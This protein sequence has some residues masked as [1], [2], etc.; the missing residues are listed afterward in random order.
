MYLEII[1]PKQ[2]TF[3][4]EVKLIQLPGIEGS[5]EIL[6]NHMPIIALLKKGKIKIVDKNNKEQFFDIEKGM[7]EFQNNKGIILSDM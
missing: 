5:F 7:F 2:T 3:S 1:T 6:K 4:G